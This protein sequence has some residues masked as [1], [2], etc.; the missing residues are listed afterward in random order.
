MQAKSKPLF[1]ICESPLHA[2]S[3]ADLGYV[4]QPIQREKHTGFP[5]IESSSMK[6]ALR[7]AYETKFIANKD[8]NGLLKVHRTFGYDADSANKSINSSIPEKEREFMGCIGFS[9]ARLLLFPVKSMRGIYAWVTCRKV[10]DKLVQDMQG[11]NPHFKIEG[12]PNIPNSTSEAYSINSVASSS[13][14]FA[15]NKTVI[16]EEYAFEIKHQPITVKETVADQ[17]KELYAWLEEN[18]LRD[19][20]S[21]YWK[22][23]MNNDILLLSDEDFKDF[24]SLST[25]VITRNK[26]NNDTGTVSNTGLFTEEYLPAESILY[27]MVFANN[28]FSIRP[29]NKLT[30]LEVMQFFDELPLR[31]QIGGNATLGKGRIRPVWQKEINPTPSNQDDNVEE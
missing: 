21:E 16:L 30:A 18:V 26:I 8:T 11:L 4:D 24:V 12:V 2:G 25:E 28:E 1:L 5:K 31:I 13:L 3:G 29:K 6:G 20:D 17:G 22:A 14:V 7:E 9:D 27:T 15:D 23:K 10:L 19:I